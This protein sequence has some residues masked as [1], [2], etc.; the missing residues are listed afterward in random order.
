MDTRGIIDS[1]RCD[2]R[3]GRVGRVGHVRPVRL[4]GGGLRL[5]AL[6]TA[7]FV[8]TPLL[9]GDLTPQEQRGKQIY[10]DGTSPRGEKIGA[11]VGESLTE[12]PGSVATCASCHGPDGRGRPEAGV[13][14]SDVTWDYLFK[15][16]GHTHPQGRNHPAFTVET[17][18]ESIVF[19]RDPA[20]NTIEASMPIYLMSDE[21]LDD[22]VAYMRKLETDY[23][24]GLSGGEL[25][26]G[27]LLPTR[28]QMAVIGQGIL[29]VLAA[30]VDDLNARGGIH[31][32][33]LRLIEFPYDNTQ[34]TPLAEATRLVAE[35]DVFALV[36]PVVIGADAEIGKLAESERVPVIG[37]LTLASPD[38]YSLNDFTFY[39][40]A[41]LAE[42]VRGLVDFAAGDLAL[43][44]ARI[45]VL[46]ADDRSRGLASAITAQCEA[47]GCSAEI[48]PAV[49]EQLAAARPDA[50][51]YLGSGDLRALLEK[52]DE[53]GW[54]P[55]VLLPGAYV[56]EELFDLPAGFHKRVYLSY[57]TV[58]ADQ[59]SAALAE[60]RS[61]L[62]ARGFA[63][64]HRASQ[65][66]ALVAARILAEGL[67]AAGR[68]LSRAK[69]L[70]ALEKLYEF[71]TGLTPAITYGA[72]RRIG[73]LGTYVVTLDLESRDFTPV[74]GWIVPR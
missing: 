65:I 57:P 31:Q 13:I 40:F 53:I 20:G 9:A 25:R 28:G 68:D 23:D 59:T 71:E 5:A 44:G 2:D 45:A 66:S 41:G 50:V 63:E 64:R 67:K 1:R 10:M 69:L 54:R 32:R 36:S 55:Y 58:P 73:A 42:Q 16:Y 18:K 27:T 51:F 21:D 37:P 19:G 30:F 15:P 17:L 38:P 60:F 62:E 72:N 47:H 3:V 34:G 4:F 61:L 74:G 14:P 49:A 46:A 24:P 52:A 8:A 70:V 39:L 48:V 6:L 12:V 29:E 11:Y 43:A 35:G 26:I 22:L 33:H 7:L 56:S